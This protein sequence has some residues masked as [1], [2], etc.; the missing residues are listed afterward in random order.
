MAGGG[1]GC[2]QYC[3]PQGCLLL[4]VLARVGDDASPGG[5]IGMRM[6]P[7]PFQPAGKLGRVPAMRE[8]P[9]AQGRSQRRGVWVLA[10]P[11]LTQPTRCG[12]IR[13]LSVPGLCSGPG[14]FPQLCAPLWG[15][16]THGWAPGRGVGGVRQRGLPGLGQEGKGK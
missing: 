8:P 13:A 14:T 3:A 6:R 7:S 5:A 12:A 2:P 15:G 11:Q 1:S 10:W 9:P 4:P 16:G